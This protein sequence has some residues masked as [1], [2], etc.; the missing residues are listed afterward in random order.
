MCLQ[1][2]GEFSQAADRDIEI[3]MLGSTG[4]SRESSIRELLPVIFGPRDLGLDPSP[5]RERRK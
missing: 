2:I 4:E 1:Y 5:Y 3:L